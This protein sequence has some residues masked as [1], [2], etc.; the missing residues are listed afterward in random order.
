VKIH[1]L[2]RWIDQ[3]SAIVLAFLAKIGFSNVSRSRRVHRRKN[4]IFFVCPFVPYPPSTGIGL[5]VYRLLKW[6]QKAGF[7]VVL[8]ISAD[9]ADAASIAQLAR[10]TTSVHWVKPKHWDSPALRTRL[11][12][13]F[14][15][16]RRVVWGSVKPRLQE[17][18]GPQVAEEGGLPTPE[19]NRKQPI[20]RSDSV[21]SIGDDRVKAWFASIKL[22]RLINRLA[23]KYHPRVVMVEYIYSTPVFECFPEET[24]K[25]VDTIDV[26]SRKGGQVLA[27]GIADP[28][29]CTEADERCH[30]L[31]ADLVVAIQSREAALLQALVPE[32]KVILAGVDFDVMSKLSAD[33]STPFRIAVVASDNPLNVHGLTEFLKEC[34]PAIKRSCPEALLHVVGRVGNLCQIADSSIQYSGWIAD[35]TEVYREASVVINPTIAGTGLKI[36]SVEAIA[37][38]K[39]LV[40][41]PHGVDGLEY[42]GEPPFVECR[43]WKEF[44]EAVTRLLASDADRVALAGRALAYAKN[45]FDA[46]SVYAELNQR[47]RAVY[48]A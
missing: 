37:H 47:L 17:F 13:R 34:W 26:F 29:A 32:R 21:Q 45:Q 27:F 38:G 2:N 1:A 41:W 40:A 42:E 31:N 10:I 6:M 28:L 9:A 23:R 5:R 20:R 8:V 12:R 14:P 4:V 3:E 48:P 46:T 22:I 11:G 36:K 18:R 24:L 35:L 7:E 25:I 39:P 15:R 16:V 43:S 19:Q 30:L 44:G 33:S